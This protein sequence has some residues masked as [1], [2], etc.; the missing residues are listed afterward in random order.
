MN[1]NINIV[2]DEFAD[3]MLKHGL[4]TKEQKEKYEKIKEVLEPILE[5][6]PEQNKIKEPS[7]NK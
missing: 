1:K 3:D 5:E 4:L 6:K 7:E 2:E